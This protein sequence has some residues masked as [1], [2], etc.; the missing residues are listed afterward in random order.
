MRRRDADML[1]MSIRNYSQNQISPILGS[2]FSPQ[3]STTKRTSAFGLPIFPAHAL[4]EKRDLDVIMHLGLASEDKIKERLDA[5][6]LDACFSPQFAGINRNFDDRKE[7]KIVK[8]FNLNPKT[9][10]QGL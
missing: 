1:E 5:V 2:H 6:G 7:S 9:R 8:K 3:R 4:H 10:T